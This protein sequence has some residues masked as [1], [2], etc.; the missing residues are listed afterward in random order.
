MTLITF[1]RQLHQKPEANCTS[2]EAVTSDSIPLDRAYEGR[3]HCPQNFRPFMRRTTLQIPLGSSR[4][5]LLKAPESTYSVS[6]MPWRRQPSNFWGSVQRRGGSPL[7]PDALP[8]TVLG[9]PP[10]LP[11]PFPCPAPPRGEGV[12]RGVTGLPCEVDLLMLISCDHG[13]IAVKSIFV[14]FKP[15]TGI[16]ISA[17]IQG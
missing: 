9:H 14:P 15:Q 11:G 1:R 17:S 10:A 8:G 2:G 4:L 5:S 13:N 12:W 6:H 3:I 16:T 7:P